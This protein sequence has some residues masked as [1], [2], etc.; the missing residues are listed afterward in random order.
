L[1]TMVSTGVSGSARMVAIVA[2]SSRDSIANE[3]V[4]EVMVDVVDE[5][6]LEVEVRV[7]IL[8]REGSESGLNVRLGG[9]EVNQR[10]A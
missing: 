1:K 7:F 10:Y 2:G 5:N 9:L 3:V 6:E 8:L 4:Y